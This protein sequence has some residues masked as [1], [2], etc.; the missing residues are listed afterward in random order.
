[1]VEADETIVGGVVDGLTGR[2]VTAAEGKTQVQGA[3]QVLRWR[4]QEGDSGGKGPVGFAWLRHRGLMNRA[5]V[6]S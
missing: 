2:W 3:V 4:N 6:S 5:S 1:M